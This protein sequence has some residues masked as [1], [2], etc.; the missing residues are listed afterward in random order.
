MKRF[1][2]RVILFLSRVKQSQAKPP[3][4]P[5]CLSAWVGVVK[6]EVQGEQQANILSIN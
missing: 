1:L 4:R 6:V 5:C 3:P 2:T